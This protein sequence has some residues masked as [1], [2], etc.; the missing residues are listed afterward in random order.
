MLKR[1]I[2]FL[3][4]LVF[5]LFLPSKVL[6]VCPVCTV[7]IGAG[8]GLSRYFG[9][10]DSVTGIWVGG[11]MMSMSFWL[12]NWMKGRKFKI[13]QKTLLS[14]IFV[15][16]ISIVPLFYTGIIGHALNKLW[17]IDKL[18][19][20]ISIGSLIFLL[21]VGTDKFLRSKNDGKV[22]IY[23]QK[24]IIPVSLLL[25]SSLVFYLITKK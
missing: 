10:D 15:Y 1:T 12:S 8:V 9:I 25:I 11:F 20:G 3:S 22:F 21:S 16:L 5:M 13:P 7:A 18:I 2:P 17:G 4:F 23:Y 19:L 6:A 14:I 24:V